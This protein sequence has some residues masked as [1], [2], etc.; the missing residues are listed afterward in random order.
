MLKINVLINNYTYIAITANQIQA[1]S[2]A[3]Y[4]EGPC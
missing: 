1:G 4:I 3:T 2:G